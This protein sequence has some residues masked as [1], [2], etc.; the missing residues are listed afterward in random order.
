MV[1][2]LGSGPLETEIILQTR[3]G[4]NIPNGQN[5]E[6]SHFERSQFDQIRQAF[7]TNIYRT[8][9]NPIYNCH[10]M[11]F[12][13]RRTGIYDSLS[14]QRILDEDGY[15]EVE[16]GNVLPG[17]II[18][19]FDNTNDFEHSG[20]VVSWDKQLSVPLVVSKWGKFAEVV[21]WGNQCPYNFANVHYYRLTKWE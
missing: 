15:T 7:P 20:L 2:I 21:H 9:P 18:I 11:V 19:Y 12:A 13:S 10:G 1:L 6:F 16:R 5:H 8:P 3:K 4:N 14:L 17:D